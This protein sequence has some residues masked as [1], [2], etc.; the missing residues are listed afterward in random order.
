VSRRNLLA[1]LALHTAPVSARALRGDDETQSAIC[2]RLNRLR[3]RG[4]VERTA[5]YGYYRYA[6]TDLGRASVALDGVIE[7]QER[8]AAEAARLIR[9]RVRGAA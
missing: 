2:N 4:L 8:E 6:I 7:R 5:T 1:E 3:I 9:A